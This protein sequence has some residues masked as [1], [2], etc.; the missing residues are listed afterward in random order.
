MAIGK[1]REDMYEDGI[2]DPRFWQA[3]IT[4][5]VPAAPAGAVRCE[6]RGK[7]GNFAKANAHLRGVLRA[8]FDGATKTWIVP[9]AMAQFADSGQAR[10]YG[11]VIVSR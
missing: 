8:R 3:D 10:G 9:A 2:D 1:G 6:N 7:G 4:P 5:V 11:I